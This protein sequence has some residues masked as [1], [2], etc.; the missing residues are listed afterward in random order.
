MSRPDAETRLGPL[1][2]GQHQVGKK[3]QHQHPTHGGEGGHDPTGHLHRVNLFGIGFSLGERTKIGR[4]DAFASKFWRLVVQKTFQINDQ[5]FGFLVAPFSFL[6]H[7]DFDHL[8]HPGGEFVV[9]VIGR[10][11]RFPEVLFDDFVYIGAFERGTAGDHVV[12]GRAQ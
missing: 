11:K 4:L 8:A 10:G 3:A 2:K 7:Q 6:G 9:K 1:A 5:I 12:K